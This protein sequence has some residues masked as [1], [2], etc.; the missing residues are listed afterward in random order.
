[1]SKLSEPCENISSA[2]P[3]FV[4]AVIYLHNDAEHIV[5]FYERLDDILRAGFANYEM[6]FVADGV[7]DDSI[8]RLKEAALRRKGKAF[9]PT[10]L[11]M[12]QFH[13]LEAAMNAGRDLAIG[14]FVYE[15]DS[16]EMDYPPEMIMQLYE[17]T[18][19]GFDLVAAA[20]SKNS[21]SGAGLF[22]RFFKS[23][24]SDSYEMRTERF[25][26]LTRRVINQVRTMGVTVPY[27]KAVY[28]SSGFRAK[29]VKYV[30]SAKRK[31]REARGGYRMNLA[32]ES[33][34]LFTQVGF[35][36]SITM[37][38]LMM[39]L[40]LFSLIYTVVYYIVGTPIEGWTTT[41]LLLSFGFFGLFGILTIVV[42]YL[43]LILGTVHQK[44][45][46]IV[47]RIEKLGE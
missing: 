28:A 35:K 17:E 5:P 15:F 12:H 11:H 33:L 1:M 23:M 9:L 40:A 13:G 43:S 42:K 39:G 19:S 44:K 16:I 14:D 22:Y 41:M 25:R 4:S 24:N 27:R 3:C 46:Y 7:R 47:S 37:T 36:F 10:V 2:A 26:I 29:T 38:L 20:P 30:Q 18:K 45:Y 32:M 31:R 8:E 21:G 34:L 6:I